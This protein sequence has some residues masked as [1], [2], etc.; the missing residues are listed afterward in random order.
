MTLPNKP[1]SPNQEYYLTQIG[2][3]LLKSKLG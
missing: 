1:S 2:K 3:D